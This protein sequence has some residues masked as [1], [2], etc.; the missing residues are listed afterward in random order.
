MAGVHPEVIAEPELEIKGSR[1]MKNVKDQLRQT[2]RTVT[3]RI[4]KY[5]RRYN[6]LPEIV[7]ANIDPNTYK[8]N[9]NYKDKAR[10]QEELETLLT[11]MKQAA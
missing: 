10:T 5:K 2:A 1:S 3:T 11:A 9:D 4:A 8:L 6:S 7:K